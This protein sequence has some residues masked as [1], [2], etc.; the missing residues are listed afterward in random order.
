MDESACFPVTSITVG[1]QPSLG[2]FLIRFDFLTNPLQSPDQ[3]NPGRNY[4]LTPVQARYLAEKIQ[5]Q[6]HLL[7]SGAS[8]GT[9]DQK[10]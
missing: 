3:P 8:P 2:V 1:P 10:H 5:S 7:E 4:L 6:L 9:G